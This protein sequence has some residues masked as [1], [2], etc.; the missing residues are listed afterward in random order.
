MQSRHGPALAA[1]L[2][3]PIRKKSEKELS[4]FVVT[5]AE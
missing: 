5:A 2:G 1:G 4:Y 3:R